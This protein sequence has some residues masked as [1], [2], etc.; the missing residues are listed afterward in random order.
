[1]FPHFHKKESLSVAH[2]TPARPASCLPWPA[3]GTTSICRGSFAGQMAAAAG[4]F[5]GT[6][7]A[8]QRRWRR[9]RA[10]G[11]TSTGFVPRNLRANRITMGAMGEPQRA[12]TRTTC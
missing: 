4:K 2:E 7:T 1:M 6:L 12:A 11:D 5:L 3:P 8:D 9:S 10:S